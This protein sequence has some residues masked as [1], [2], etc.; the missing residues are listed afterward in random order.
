MSLSFLETDSFVVL[1]KITLHFISFFI[2]RIEI[3][4]NSNS[5]IHVRI[6]DHSCSDEES[7]GPSYPG[8]RVNLL[9]KQNKSTH[10][11]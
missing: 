8:I 2:F 4:L 9:L 6:R 5:C 1:R 11:F 10:A 3:Q 7:T